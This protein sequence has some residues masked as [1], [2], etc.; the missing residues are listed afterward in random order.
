[1]NPAARNRIKVDVLRRACLAC[2]S[3]LEETGHAEV[4]LAYDG[5]WSIPH[6]QAKGDAPPRSFGYE[7]LAHSY[8]QVERVAD[9]KLPP[10]AFFLSHVAL[11]LNQL[12]EEI[13]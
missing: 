2:L 11:L 10:A 8:D 1:V 7:S 6:D 9:G 12:G 5:V 3:G 13:E 4:D